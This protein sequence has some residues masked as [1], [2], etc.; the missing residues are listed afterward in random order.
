MLSVDGKAIT[1]EWDGL[2][3][4]R[5]Y[6]TDFRQGSD[7]KTA[8]DVTQ[9]GAVIYIRQQEGQWRI[10]QIPE[11]SGAFIALNPKNGAVE[12]VVQATAFIKASLTGQHRPSDKWAQTSSLSFILLH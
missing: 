8:S 12:A 1:V 6:I 4:A 10:S 7:P 11:V 5:R 2:D 3:W 9:E